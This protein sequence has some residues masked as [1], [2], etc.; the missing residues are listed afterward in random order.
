VKFLVLMAEE[1]TWNRWSS[2]SDAEQQQVFD[3][4]T[5][6]TEA[7]KARGSVLAG[8]A[9]DRPESAR[10]IR[11]AAGNGRGRAVTEGPFA[12]TV[13]QL[14]GFWLVDLPDLDAAVEAAT[15]L[16]AAYSVEVRPVVDMGD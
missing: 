4:F 5:A 8:E 16:P 13:E 11:P 2:L 10:T 7:V 14:G 9:L 15:L 12:E 1:D 6:F 3:R